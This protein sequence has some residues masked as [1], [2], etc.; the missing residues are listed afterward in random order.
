MSQSTPPPGLFD[1]LRRFDPAVLPILVAAV[2]LVGAV[3]WLLGRPLPPPAAAV[4]PRLPEQVA[5]LRAEVE[6]L[7]GVQSRIAALE[8]RGG[9][10]LRPLEGRLAALEGRTGPDVAPLAAGIAAATGRAE[11][12]E[13]RLTAAEERLGALQR[14][15]AGRPVV[16]PNALAPRAAL[17]QLSG[18][19]EALARETQ[20]AAAQSAGRVQAAEQAIAG[21]AGR[22]AA[23]EAGLA[24]R[25]QAIEAQ[26]GRIGAL[27][28]A[29]NSRIQ[30][31][32]A[33][34]TQ[35]LQALEGQ[36]QQRGA[37]LE[38]QGQRLQALEGTAGRLA[39]LEG[40]SARLSAID[41]VRAALEA[42]RP[43]G[44]ALRPL[45]DPPA[46]LTRFAGTAP[47]TEAGLRLSFEEAARAGRAAGE[48]QGS[49][50]LDSAA[51]RL[52]GLVTVRRGEEVLWGDAAAA[53]IER[54]RRAVE[55]GDLEGA[56]RFLQRLSAPARQAMAGWIGQA[57]AL[58]AARAALRQMAA[59]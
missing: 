41:S 5:A 3:I 52:G 37:A 42:G 4:D 55:A 30:A 19:V 40:R 59:G 13:R 1:R 29:M 15:L 20:G 43:L 47:P 28:Q 6:R 32:E 33:N 49:G 48:P 7:Q 50:V 16:D 56:L 46:P 9:P 26:A 10:D 53:E 51:Q 31:L 54:A 44:E 58:I 23:N 2:V 8:G 17:D 12:A 36:L 21:F 18:R 34:I 39:A 22:V 57:E 27:E 38:Q 24:A 25:T 11:T 14:E 45:Q 35:R